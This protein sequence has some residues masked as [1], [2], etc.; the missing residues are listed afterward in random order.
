MCA[1]STAASLH[2]ELHWSGWQKQFGGSSDVS[3]ACSAMQGVSHPSPLASQ[4]FRIVTVHY[5]Y[6]PM[7]LMPREMAHMAYWKACHTCST[8]FPLWL[9][10]CWIVWQTTPV[11]ISVTVWDHFNPGTK[12]WTFIHSSCHM[13]STTT[14]FPRYL[15]YPDEGC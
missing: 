6:C 11:R 12:P 4:K 14:L 2:G 5:A 9:H 13:T 8:A 1:I 15:E 3:M 7:A 10:F